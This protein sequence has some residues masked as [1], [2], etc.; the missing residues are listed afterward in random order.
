M[1]INVHVPI[2][3]EIQFNYM[4]IFIADTLNYTLL[5]ERLVIPMWCVGGGNF[6][7]PSLPPTYLDKSL[8]PKSELC[9]CN[10]AFTDK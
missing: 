5:C 2:A 4:F 6:L 3:M 9:K 8:T 1:L 7:S 10:A